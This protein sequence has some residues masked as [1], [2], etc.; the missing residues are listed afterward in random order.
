[1]Y[2]Y[3]YKVLKEWVFYIGL[4]RVC[5]LR[6]FKVFYYVMFMKLRCYNGLDLD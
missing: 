5:W 6:F 2:D 1:M 4:S 3:G